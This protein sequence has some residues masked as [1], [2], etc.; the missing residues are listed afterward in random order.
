V[1][2][3]PALF[4]IHLVRG[5]TIPVLYFHAPDSSRK[6]AWTRHPGSARGCRYDTIERCAWQAGS[7]AGPGR[8]Q[9]GSL[10]A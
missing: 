2:S 6:P 10:R 1:S 7:S 8:C 5:R 4:T 9:S 3:R